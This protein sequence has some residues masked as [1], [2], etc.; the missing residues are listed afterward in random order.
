[1][2]FDNGILG[3]SVVLG[4]VLRAFY[5]LGRS[6]SQIDSAGWWRYHLVLWNMVIIYLVNNFTARYL[7]SFGNQFSLLMIFIMVC[8]RAELL[9]R[10]E[11]V[12]ASSSRV[13]RIPFGNALQMR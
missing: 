12:S 10:A 7:F 8:Q 11:P 9:G 13:A 1:M 3:G 6:T 2:L 5:W 4:S